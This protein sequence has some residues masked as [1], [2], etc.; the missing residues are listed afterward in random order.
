MFTLFLSVTKDLGEK[1][2]GGV[3]DSGEGFAWSAFVPS[4]LIHAMAIRLLFLCLVLVGVFQ[5]MY[6]AVLDGLYFRHKSV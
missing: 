6:V 4:F 5:M 1:N 3:E 2:S